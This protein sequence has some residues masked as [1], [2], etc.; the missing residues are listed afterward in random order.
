MQSSGTG[1]DGIYGEI[2]VR[3]RTDEGLEAEIAAKLEQAVRQDRSLL[4]RLSR[5]QARRES[6][7]HSLGDI[8]RRHR[9]SCPTREQLG[10][11]LLGAVTAELEDYIRFH[12]ETVGCRFCAANLEDLQRRQQE[13]GDATAT[14][15]RKYFE[16]SAGYLPEE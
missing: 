2:G 9:T 8:W 3:I 4:D 15:R 7:L 1:E 12:I 14:R 13:S 11:Y 10:S 16:S 6:G 5:L